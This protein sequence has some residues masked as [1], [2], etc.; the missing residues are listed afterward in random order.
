M[1][2][3]TAP[4]TAACAATFISGEVVILKPPVPKLVAEW[5]EAQ[6]TVPLLR[7][8]GRTCWPEGVTKVVVAPIQVMPTVWQVWQARATVVWPAADSAGVVPVTNP[9]PLLVIGSL[10][11]WQPLAAQSWPL[12]GI[13]LPAP[14]VPCVPEICQGWPLVPWPLPR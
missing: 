1:Q 10:I 4:A 12:I 9:A 14:G 6:A 5:H 8:S 11:E 7:L 13:W 3:G 2:A